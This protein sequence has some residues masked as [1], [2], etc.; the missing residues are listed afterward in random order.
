[1]DHEELLRRSF[2]TSWNLTK[3][4]KFIRSII[5]NWKVGIKNKN[6]ETL[7]TSSFS[8]DSHLAFIQITQK[9]PSTAL[10]AGLQQK[11]GVGD[12]SGE[13]QSLL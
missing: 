2:G 4:S 11:R 7:L 13:I 3:K 1:M 12:A 10:G 8:H 6:M 9:S 5:V